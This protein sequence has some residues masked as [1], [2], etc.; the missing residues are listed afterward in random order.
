MLIPLGANTRVEELGQA[1]QICE[2]CRKEA[3]HQFQSRQTWFTILHIAVFAVG[4][5]QIVSTCS[6][7]GHVSKSVGDRSVLAFI[8]RS[9]PNCTRTISADAT[10]CGGCGQVLTGHD[11]TKS[12]WRI[13][14]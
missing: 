2:K 5:K 1:K 10:I 12:R 14:E 8:T 9:C 3:V 11:K 7:C 4:E 6:L 13:E